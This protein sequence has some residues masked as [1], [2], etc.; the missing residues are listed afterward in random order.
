MTEVFFIDWSQNVFLP[1]V[2]HLRE[3]TK[4]QGKVVLILVD[5]ATSAIFRVIADVGSQGLSL[6]RLVPHSSHIAQPLDLYIFGLL[7]TI[8]HKERKSKAMKGETRKMYC[9]LF[10]FYK[11]NIIPMV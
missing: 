5:H 6:I 1:R 9:V 3:R 4:Y 2:S 11:L 10:A 7:K 8:Y